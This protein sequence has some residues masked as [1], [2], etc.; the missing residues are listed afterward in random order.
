MSAARHTQ[1]IVLGF[2]VGPVSGR[3]VEG[4]GQDGDES[5]RSVNQ[6]RNVPRRDNAQARTSE[7]CLISEEVPR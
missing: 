2:A 4:S 1:E 7:P 3:L 6:R 5:R